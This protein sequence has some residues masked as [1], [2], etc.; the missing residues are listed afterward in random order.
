MRQMHVPT[1]FASVHLQDHAGIAGRMVERCV[2]Q[3]KI[4]PQLFHGDGTPVDQQ[5]HFHVGGVPALIRWRRR[6][7][8]WCRTHVP[9]LEFAAN[10]GQGIEI[11]RNQH[12]L[13]AA[14]RRTPT[15]VVLPLLRACSFR[16]VNDASAWR[17]SVGAWL[18]R[19]ATS[20]G[21]CPPPSKSLRLPSPTPNRS[22]TRRS[23]ARPKD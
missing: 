1:A 23:T 10:R 11:R 19:S 16:L 17:T 22:D 9:I 18:R 21:P 12:A 8:F 14:S 3:K 5:P 6:K 4:R 20:S 2:H 7:R 13:R 15:P